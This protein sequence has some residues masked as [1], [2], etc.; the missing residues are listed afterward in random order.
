MVMTSNHAG[1]RTKKA[2]KLYVEGAGYWVEDYRTHLE[3]L[4]AEAP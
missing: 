1:F 4:G 2:I 3:G